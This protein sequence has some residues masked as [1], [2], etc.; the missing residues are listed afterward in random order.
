MCVHTKL[1]SPVRRQGWRRKRRKRRRG[2]GCYLELGISL[3]GRH[4]G[5]PRVREVHFCVSDAIPQCMYTR[6]KDFL[7]SSYIG[8]L[9]EAEIQNNRRRPSSLRRSTSIDPACREVTI[10]CLGICVLMTITRKR[11]EGRSCPRRQPTL[12]RNAEEKEVKTYSTDVCLMKKKDRREEKK[13]SG[14]EKVGEE[15]HHPV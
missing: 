3:R 5:S 1:P 8:Y 9:Q 12:R 15:F 2:Q 6:S 14:T 11:K 4:S 13:K 7:S 10:E